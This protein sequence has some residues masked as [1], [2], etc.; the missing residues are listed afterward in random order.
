VT[1]NGK[2]TYIGKGEGEMKVL[3]TGGAGGLGTTVCRI[4]LRERF[5]V[6]LFDVDSHKNRKRVRNLGAGIDIMW[7]DITKIES[8]R[9]A[10]DGIDAVV[11]LAG[12]LPPLTEKD[13]EL[14]A[15]V[16]IG[17]PQN[18]VDLIKEK[19]EP[20]PFV[21][22]SSTSVFGP[23]PDAT[24]PLHPDRNPP[25][26]LTTYAKTKLQT[27]EIVRGSG[28]PYIILRLTSVPH[29]RPNFKLTDMRYSFFSIPLENRVEFVHPEDVALAIVNAV[30][31]FEAAKDNTLIIAG[32]P[33][34]QM[35]YK[36]MLRA[37]FQ[38]LG[39]PL[40]PR[41]KFTKEPYD[42]DWYDTSRS[43]ALLQFQQK[44]LADYSKD[45]SERMFTP[46]VILMR[47]FIGPVFG[48]VIVRLL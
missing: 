21:V 31:D 32:G 26:P 11:H 6:R 41:H 38:P 34:Q 3:I 40:P 43:Q 4:F 10:M 18:I 16:N 48:R 9:R 20:I 2:N 12:I 46:L 25:N 47:Y 24:E 14:A 15:R 36:D 13:P 23:T 19:G 33:S 7:G 5:Y 1:G 39:L 22:I 44:N 30:K 42:L 8:V 29:L 17:G 45:M 27:E 28:I 37:V 35:V